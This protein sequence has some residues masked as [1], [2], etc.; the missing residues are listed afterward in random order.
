MCTA[1]EV[2]VHVCSVH[3][4]PAGPQAEAVADAVALLGGDTI[5]V[6]HMPPARF[7]DAGGVRALARS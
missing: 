2:R 6:P 3:A 1:T 4:T 7:A 5:I